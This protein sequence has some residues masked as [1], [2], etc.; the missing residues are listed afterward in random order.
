MKTVIFI[1]QHFRT[2]EEG[3]GIRSFFLAEELVKAGNNVIVLRGGTKQTFN[4]SKSFTV[5]SL[6]NQYDQTF[7]FTNRIR[8]FAGF[9]WSCIRFI[10]R[11]S[12]KPNLA[13][14][15]STPLSVGFVGV[16]A[17]KRLG[18]PFVF[19]VGDLWPDVPIQ[20]GI[21]RNPLLKLI[22]SKL[23]RVSYDNSIMI[24]SLSE[25]ISE[26]IRKKNKASEI[27]TIPNFSDN[28]FFGSQDGRTTV[29][30]GK[31]HLGYFGAAG[32][33]NGLDFIA[34]LVEL[35]NQKNYPVQF[36]FMM[37]GSELGVFQEK[38]RSFE[39]VIF[40]P[41]GNRE[42]VKETLDKIDVGLVSFSNYSLLGTGSPNKL[43]DYLAAGK[44]VICN[45][46]GWFQ[47]KIERS[48]CGFYIPYNSPELL[49][50]KLHQILDPR[51]YQRLSANA[52]RL[53]KR[54]FDKNRLLEIWKKEMLNLEA[55]KD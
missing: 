50:E 47:S 44:V 27:L 41:Y 33:A 19:E 23:E 12:P 24:C 20:M 5:H 48:E 28:E 8:S 21:L 51:N 11:L 15:I 46:Q 18:I 14:V 38:V 1:H 49:F 32:K 31:L 3:G 54:E 29:E 52:K 39:N 34:R 30:S 37:E 45:S 43:F 16:Y 55:L 25:D 4:P 53:A 26:S 42:K 6:G 40:Y 35:S 9:S 17:R 10:R 36:H 2:P 13:Y 22:S 7:S